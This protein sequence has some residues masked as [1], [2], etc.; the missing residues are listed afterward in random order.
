MRVIHLSAYDLYGGAAKAAYRLHV[1]LAAT[2]V[3]SRMLVRRRQSGRSDII[4]PAGRLMKVWCRVQRRCDRLV[5][6]LHGRRSGEFSPGNVPDGLMR[7][8]RTFAPDIVH[9]HWVADGFFRIESLARLTVPVVWTMHDM[10]PFTGGCHYAGSCE[11]FT[12]ICGRCPMLNSR[13]E[14]DLA[15]TGWERRQTTFGRNRPV[16]VAPS[17]WMENQARRSAL[18]RNADVRTIA[19]GIDTDCFTPRDRAAMRTKL[20]LPQDKTLVLAGAAQLGANPRK[21]FT[22]FISALRELRGL[23]ASGSTEVVLFGSETSGCE[24]L[25]G[26]RTHKLGRLEGDEALAT[27]Y[28][29][30]DIFVV[31]SL[32]DNL[33][34]TVIE[35]MAAGT[36]VVAYD[37]GGIPEIVDNG[38]NGLLAPVGR[39]EALAQALARMLK[40]DDFRN[41]CRQ[42]AHEKAL[43]CFDVR[44]SADR[45]HALYRELSGHL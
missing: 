24:E 3:D 6:A 23:V 9:L 5:L 33:P 41:R 19:N 18:L 36:P 44:K 26:F 22:H 42:R 1:A 34:N 43:H 11:R 30:A 25:E 8:L 39:P 12:N 28:A 38:E 35:A 37:V 2:G 16:F 31:P 40:D 17:R 32:E 45:Y 4:Q 10:W 29:S 27:A 20:A 7:H 14:H 13:R 15:R 21:G